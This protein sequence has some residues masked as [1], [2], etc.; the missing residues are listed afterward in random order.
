MFV[1][2]TFRVI[3]RWDLLNLY[4]ICVHLCN[5]IK[6]NYCRNHRYCLLSDSKIRCLLFD[7]IPAVGSSHRSLS[8]SSAEERL[9]SPITDPAHS[10][11]M[12]AGGGD[13]TLHSVTDGVLAGGTESSVS[14]AETASSPGPAQPT[15]VEQSGMAN[16]SAGSMAFTDFATETL[17]PHSS[18]MPTY[19]FQNDLTSKLVSPGGEVHTV[20]L[21]TL[22][23]GFVH[24]YMQCHL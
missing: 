15:L 8:S 14:Y 4:L 22:Y 12:S 13:R 9:S 16:A 11:S 21:P 20:P 19:S 18:K 5:F 3:D 6:Q 17:F 7:P 24:W 23:T 10:S 2:S 1:R